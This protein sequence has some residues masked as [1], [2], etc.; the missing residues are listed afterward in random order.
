[1]DVPGDRLGPLPA[2]GSAATTRFTTSEACAQC[3]LAGDGTAIR[4]AKGR[5]VSPVGTWRT[6]AMAL[7]TRDPYYLAAFADELQFRP[8]LADTVEATCTRCH[9]PAGALELEVEGKTP[10]FAML[11]TG[12]DTSKAAHLAR[13]GVA[14]SLCHQ[15]DAE[16]LGTYASFTGQFKV[17]DQRRIY[18][19][20]QD[21]ATDPMRTLVNYVPTYGAHIQKSA[22][23]ATCH[24]VIT[25]P[26]DARGYVGPD[27][28]EQVPFLEWL[29]SSFADG[30]PKA[31]TCQDCHMQAADDDGATLE[32]PIARNPAGLKARKPF[33]RHGF[34]G[35]NVQLARFGASDPAWFGVP[36]T[37]DDHERQAKA[38]ERMLARAAKVDVSTTPGEIAVTITN[39]SGHKLPTGY[40]SRRLIVHLTVTAPDGKVVWESGKVDEFGR[41]AKEPA[42][43]FPH[44]DVVTKQEDV[45]IYE[46]FPIDAAGKPAHRPLDS[47]KYAKDNRLV[48]SGFNKRNGFS[49]YTGSIGV[50]QDPDWGSSD[51]VKYRVGDVPAGSSVTAELLFQ[52]VRPSDIEV[53][54]S[55]PTPAARRLFDFAKA[56]P[57]VPVVIASAT[58]KTP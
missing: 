29:A 18:G 52:V 44:F 23:C 24:T 30:G 6:S 50:D 36:L 57:P 3:H 25:K 28:P 4:D 48:P 26:R 11:T 35:A 31:A 39:E 49:A 40:P 56:A 46:S 12:A 34:E 51:T 9:A 15:I 5:D 45:Q 54:A 41:L 33:W 21:P 22:L 38:N 47:L 8:A 37:K 10:T 16:G 53:Y 32:T 2:Q 19:P 17:L 20:Y 55:K 27:F 7:A 42:T 13:E 1:M 58:A 43:F 14:C